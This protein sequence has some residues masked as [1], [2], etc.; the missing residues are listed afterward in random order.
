[1]YEILTPEKYGE[2]EEFAL[3]H[4]NGTFTQSV[5]WADVKKNWGH[6]VIVSRDEEGRIRGG[7]AVLTRDLPGIRKKLIYA[8][9]G[10]IFNYDDEETFADLVEGIRA[11]AKQEHGFM[12]KMDPMVDNDN[13]AFIA[14]AR[15]YGFSYDPSLGDG[16]TIQRRCNYM[17]DLTPFNGDPDALI[18]SFDR[19]WRYNIRFSARQ[20]VTCEVYDT[21]E[22]LHDFHTIYVETAKRDDYTPRTEEYLKGFLDALGEHARLYMCY[23]NGVPLAGGIA[24]NYAGKVCHVYGASGNEYTKLKASHLMHWPIMCWALETGCSVYDFQGIPIDYQSGTDHMQGVYEFKKGS[25]G[26]VKLFTGEFDLVFDHVA[27]A[28]YDLAERAQAVKKKLSRR[29][30]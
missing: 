16:Q 2:Y 17:K 9:R 28:A 18:A 30:S 15:K 10:P 19:R 29:L 1:M 20:G 6:G 23:Y 14:M 11:F 13:E 4:P 7:A 24:T 12:F 8:P 3:H 26:E 27:K 5:R 21:P 22:A 25:N